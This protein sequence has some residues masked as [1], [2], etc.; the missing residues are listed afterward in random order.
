MLKYFLRIIIVLFLSITFFFSSGKEVR[1][2]FDCAGSTISALGGMQSC[3]S[4]CAGAGKGCWGITEC[5]IS[6]YV[7]C[8][9]FMQTCGT[10]C[11]YDH[12]ECKCTGAAPACVD[13]VT[14]CTDAEGV[15]NDYCATAP[16]TVVKFDCAP[17]N[18]CKQKSFS[19]INGCSASKCNSTP[20]ASVCPDGSCTGTETN[21]S[22]PADCPP[23]VC[24]NDNRC[25][26]GET[27]T[28][29][30]SD[31]L[32]FPFCPLTHCGNGLCDCFENIATCAADCTLVPK[33]NIQVA[34]KC[35]DLSMAGTGTVRIASIDHFSFD[36]TG[37]IVPWYIYTD[38]FGVITV[39]NF[40][41]ANIPFGDYEL[42][43]DTN[44]GVG[45][46]P[47]TL[48][49][50][51]PA[52]KVLSMVVGSFYCPTTTHV[53]S[54]VPYQDC[55]EVCN[56]AGQGCV[57]TTGCSSSCSNIDSSC[58]Y[59]CDGR[60]EC[61][62]SAA[63]T[64]C[65]VVDPSLTVNSSCTGFDGTAVGVF[66]DSCLNPTTMIKY[67][68]G[69][70]GNCEPNIK[71]CVFGSNLSCTAGA[72]SAAPP[73]LV[74][75]NC[76]L[77]AGICGDCPGE[78]YDTCPQ[79]CPFVPPPPPPPACPA[80]GNGLCDCGETN[81]TCAVDCPPPAVE[82]IGNIVVK[83]IGSITSDL[84]NWLLGLI[85]GLA[86]LMII[87]GGIKY[88]GAWGNADK[89]LRARKMINFV[90]IGLFIVLGSYSAV[91]TLDKIIS[92]GAGSISITS[93][94]VSPLSGPVGTTFT[95]TATI[96]APAGVDNATTIAHV[97][98]PDGVDLLPPVNILL[99][100]VGPDVY[101]G[102]WLSSAGG[103]YFVDISA[104]DINSNCNT[105]NNI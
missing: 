76:G 50:T 36:A 86:I 96:V 23:I 101:S 2:A 55:N 69:I 43:V 65:S 56:A 38:P 93:T 17:G 8:L 21:S 26:L 44:C 9:P 97:Q 100:P 79:D 70:T 31:C 51:D 14:G 68:C 80:C 92:G 28:N 48:K 57:K 33:K 3:N 35:P 59:K 89:L 18:F 41:Y 75:P 88:M 34:I 32:V 74:C 5:Y 37:P 49:N 19:C 40:N 29:C 52:D 25:D 87:L 53:D 22:C 54:T 84:N 102:T 62:C 91:I 20:P 42:S 78:T 83:P 6:G 15:H 94:S 67:L 13:S 46:L 99:V 39:V 64:P 104:C 82:P 11:N 7:G 61:E 1:A 85:A 72:C 10:E 24:D 73:P 60:T 90:I 4:V 81:G 103:P 95:F 105:A 77:G 27:S 47:F 45:T 71:D 12:L 16:N 30:P 66:T 58:N 63:K 98:S